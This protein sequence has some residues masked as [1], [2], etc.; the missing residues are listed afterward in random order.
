[1]KA[2]YALRVLVE[3]ARS[4]SAIRIGCARRA[5]RCPALAIALGTFVG[6]L[7]A[8]QA[9]SVEEL[10]RRL[11]VLE[12][13]LGV[14][15]TNAPAVAAD[16]SSVQA[17]DQRLRV[18]ERKLELQAEEAAARAAREPVI[19]ASAGKGLGLK[20]SDGVDIKLKTLVH[21]DGRF[22][23]DDATPQND[24]FQLRRVRPTLEGSWGPLLGFRLSPELAGD[25]ATI[26]DAY[27]DLKFDP[28]T[29]VRI[30]KA[31]GPV[32][33]ERL[34]GGGATA[35]IERGLPTE[36]APNRDIGVQLQGE[37]LDKTLG[38]TVGVYNGTP[39]GRDAATSNP[40]NELEYAGRVFW[41]PFKNAASGW[42]GLGLGVAASAGD[43]HGAG[44]NFLPRYRT[45]GQVQFFGYGS[46]IAADGEHR[47]LSPQGYFYR[48]PFGL[49]GEYI[50][51]GQ[52]V[53]VASGT[54]AGTV[55]RLEH[56]AYQLTAGYV[57]TGEGAS[58]RGVARPNDPFTVGGAGWGAFELVARYGALDVD[59][60]AFP[61][62]A[63]PA[64]AASRVQAWT[65]GLNWY[66][67]QNLKL[68]ANY[69]QAAFDG[70]AAAGAD[71][72]DEETFFTRAQLSF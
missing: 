46:N 43:K 64:S 41:E 24:G 68:V 11:Q 50:R 22:Y 72:E 42:S 44:N 5:M 70:G 2:K 60:A 67:N 13:R 36:L 34:Q 62:F 17:L 61:L 30:G 26:A 52:R 1:M 31:K 37:L 47:R 69:T 9:P 57:L 53:R 63:N 51:S 19:T 27:L 8:Q 49:L 23:M 35:F 10:A 38:Y 56:D 45:P 40:D 6:P 65:L 66:L 25:S 59:D 39:D 55:R 58:Y 4:A 18:I 14:G 12:S 33:L 28:R 7:Q 54:G 29:T 48:G 71:R 32:G 20:S 21:V 15:D 16:G 3:L